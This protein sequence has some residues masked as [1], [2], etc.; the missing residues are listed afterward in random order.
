MMKKLFNFITLFGSFSTIICC[1]L[2]ALL[3]FF[4]VGGVVASLIS[5]F[6]ALIVLSEHKE[7]LFLVAGVLL[8][9]NGLIQWYNKDVV[10]PVDKKMARACGSTRTVTKIIYI[11]SLIIYLC[12]LVITFVVPL[13][14]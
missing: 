12:A 13:F 5:T 10:C 7:I 6:P 1:A 4:G 9:I 11:F 14:L 8:I 3:I 2:P